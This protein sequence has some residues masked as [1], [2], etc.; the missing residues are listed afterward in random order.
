MKGSEMSK[1]VSSIDQEEIGIVRLY[2]KLVISVLTAM[3]AIT[4][5]WIRQ[6]QDL[7]LLFVET[8]RN[9]EDARLPTTRSIT[10]SPNM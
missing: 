6:W 3:K 2:N 1:I 10:H 5:E 7:A 4:M 9:D 8:C